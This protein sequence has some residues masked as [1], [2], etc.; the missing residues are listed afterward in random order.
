M[1]TNAAGQNFAQAMEDGLHRWLLDQRSGHIEQGPIPAMG[2]AS[3][4]FRHAHQTSTPST[5]LPH[6]ALSHGRCLESLPLSV[7][8]E[9][10]PSHRPSWQRPQACCPGV[11]E[12]AMNA[13]TNAK[14]NLAIQI[15]DSCHIVILLFFASTG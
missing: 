10:K 4:V 5:D 6:R 2:G 1:E 11:K 9:P 8:Y 13:T 12:H 14:P 3:I 15:R 7:C